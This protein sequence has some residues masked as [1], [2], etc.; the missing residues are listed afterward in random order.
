MLNSIEKKRIPA[1]IKQWLERRE[2]SIQ[3]VS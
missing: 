1:K 2:T 3:I